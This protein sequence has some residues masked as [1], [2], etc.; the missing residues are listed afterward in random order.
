MDVS[1]HKDA[2]EYLYVLW[3]P[4]PFSLGQDGVQT[5]SGPKGGNWLWPS[6]SAAIT[7]FKVIEDCSGVTSIYDDGCRVG[8]LEFVGYVPGIP[9][10]G[11]GVAVK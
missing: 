4:V 1:K 2:P 9:G 7:Y 5:K 10:Q 11:F 8:D 6:A 3:T